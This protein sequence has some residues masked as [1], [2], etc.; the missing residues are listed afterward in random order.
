[1]N[2]PPLSWVDENY[3]VEQD[4]DNDYEDMDND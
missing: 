2:H 4:Y 1:M 3:G